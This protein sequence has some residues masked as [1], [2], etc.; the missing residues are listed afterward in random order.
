MV[1]CQRRTSVPRYT[2]PALVAEPEVKGCLCIPLF[3]R[4]SKQYCSG[5][6]ICR[7]FGAPREQLPQQQLGTGVALACGGLQPM[8]RFRH[9]LLS[10]DAA[11]IQISEHSLR[12]SIAA[13]GCLSPQRKNASGLGFGGSF[14][15][16]LAGQY[17]QCAGMTLFS[18]L[19][20]PDCRRLAV[21]R[22]T[23]SCAQ[24]IA[25]PSLS[26]GVASLRRPAEPTQGQALVR[27]NVTPFVM[28]QSPDRLCSRVAAE[29]RRFEKGQNALRERCESTAL[30][31]PLRQVTC[32][33]RAPEVGGS[34]EPACSSGGI[35]DGGG[36]IC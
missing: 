2:D 9:R 19:L 28:H 23:L 24:C 17:R 25:K 1:G 13:L 26:E 6:R 30:F 5:D 8:P 31:K 10:A 33:G 35:G 22:D 16:L 14:A 34:L 21:D 7:Q 18:S 3:G 20:I 27:R 32:G 11:A 12:I 36:A 29:G 4:R 15:H